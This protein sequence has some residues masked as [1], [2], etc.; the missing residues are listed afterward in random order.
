MRIAVIG[1][2]LGGLSTAGFLARAGL[3]DVQ[4]YEQARALGEIGAGIQVPPNA[5][6]LL[7]RLGVVEQLDD[8]GVRLEV[9]W[10]FRRWKTGEVLYSQRLGTACEE[11]FGAPYYVAHRAGLLDALL[12]V[13]P[14]GIVHV[15]KRCAAVEETG[16]EVQVTFEDGETITADVVIGADGIHSVVRGAVT[17]PSPPTFSGLAGYRCMLPA[18]SAPPMA[19]APAFTVWLGPGRHLVH[20]PVSAGREVNL[21][22]IVPAG[23]WRTESWVAEGTLEG[24]LAEH[25]GWA[26]EVQE[27]L[28]LAPKTWLYALYD[29]EPLARFVRG[30]IALVGD[31]AH[32]MLPFL[33]QGAAQAFED[34]AALALCLREAGPGR[35]RLG[36]ERYERARLARAS[37]VQ[38]LSRGRRTS[39]TCPTGPSRSAGTPSWRPRTRSSTTPGCTSTTSKPRCA[40]PTSRHLCADAA[41]AART[42]HSTKS[43]TSGS[44]RSRSQAMW[45][46][47]G[48]MSGTGTNATPGRG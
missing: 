42:A 1:G 15:G 20:Y 24:L 40:A 29:R 2:G 45:N 33:A 8:A 41:S 48:S 9:G 26:D 37:E 13:L 35:A 4:V 38:R 22:A 39:T 14:D 43:R 47:D 7:H 32:P 16:E 17:T 21:V 12:G 44:A 5:V 25:V 19:L 27:L 11:R 31:A 6:R 36:L 28:G 30:R 34:G 46:G 3:D 10:E 18:E 23:E